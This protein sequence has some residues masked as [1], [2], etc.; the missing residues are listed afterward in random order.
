MIKI[1]CVGKI[2]ESFFTE[3]IKE[4]QK[5]IEGYTKFSILEVKE[6]NTQDIN[7]NILEEGKNLL[8]KIA[9]DE[10]VITLEIKG[11]RIDSVELAKLIEEKQIYGFSKITF[12]IGGSNGLSEE[13]IRRS[14]YHLSFSEFTF[15]HQLMRLILA[16]QIY[17]ALTIINNK[18]YHK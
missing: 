14:N 18:E 17:R 7:K 11:K 13:V 16:E 1:L 4:Y 3:G 8:G 9:E 2:K 5:R 10:Y 15:P 12:V 6:V